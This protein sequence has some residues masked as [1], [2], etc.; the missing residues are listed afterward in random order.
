MSPSIKQPSFLPLR[1]ILVATDFSEVSKQA[2]PYAA[3]LAKQLDASVTVVHVVPT[4]P[5]AELSHIPL[6]LEE[7]R[8]VAEARSA[9]ARFREKELPRDLKGD[10]LV[11]AGSPY[12]KVCEA[13]KTLSADLI[14]T[15]THGHTGLKHFLLGSTA[16]RIVR[17]APCPVLAVR[18]PWMEIKFPSEP[19]LNFKKILVPIDFSDASR[20]ALPY[21]ASLVRQFGGVAILLHVI[22][23]PPYPEF[24]YAHVPIKE[25][26]RKRAA[27]EQLERLRHEAPL[28]A[29]SGTTV[30][31]R[32]GNAYH[33]IVSAAA[34]EKAD[35]IILSTHGRTGLAHTLLG[36]TAE[37]V[38]RHASCPVLV[39]R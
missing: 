24:G 13:A 12:A 21:A 39:V 38:V 22:E 6:V 2:L 4:P 26:K 25:A 3:A 7:K 30:D 9:L 17:H 34:D 19:A 29:A 1:Q 11:L 10:T 27:K 8:L 33:E 37:K 23:P 28:N 32:H 15:A 5:P 31:I 35:L 14:I 20:K 16:E 18:E 36:S